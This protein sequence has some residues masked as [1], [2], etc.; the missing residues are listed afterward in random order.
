MLLWGLQASLPL[1]PDIFSLASFFFFPDHFPSST[2]VRAPRNLTGPVHTSVLLSRT[3]PLA[4]L[5]VTTPMA[6]VMGGFFQLC[7]GNT[8]EV[9]LSKQFPFPW[10]QRYQLSC[11]FACAWPKEQRPVS[12]KAWR[13]YRGCL[14][15]CPVFVILASYWKIAS[16]TFTF[17][18][19]MLFMSLNL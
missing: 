12:Q 9:S 17:K 7:H 13:G 11:R 6:W 10:C 5:S 3:L 8:Y 18:L 4:C 2:L 15:S 16:Y 14:S 19:F 1:N